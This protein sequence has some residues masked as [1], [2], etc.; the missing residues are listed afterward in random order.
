MMDPAERDDKFVADFAAECT[1]LHEAEVMGIRMFTSA[2]QASLLGDEAQM[3][4]AAIAAGL[5]KS[6]QA[7]VHSCDGQIAVFWLRFG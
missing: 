6:K 4:M 2:H 1:W 5:S 3:D 7:H